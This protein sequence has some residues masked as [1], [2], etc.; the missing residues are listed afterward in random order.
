MSS[1]ENET[2]TAQ[3]SEITVTLCTF[4]TKSQQMHATIQFQLGSTRRHCVSC[5]APS[6][7]GS[8]S[9]HELRPAQIPEKKPRRHWNMMRCTQRRSTNPSGL[10]LQLGCLEWSPADPGGLC[11]HPVEQP[12]CGNA[13]THQ[14]GLSSTHD[15][16]QWLKK[17]ESYPEILF[18]RL[19]GSLQDAFS[20][21]SGT[22]AGLWGPTVGQSQL[23][24]AW[25]TEIWE[26][27]ETNSKKKQTKRHSRVNFMTSSCCFN[28]S[29][30]LTR[31]ENLREYA[32][33]S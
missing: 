18:I 12:L 21:L 27:E 33:E 22:L 23:I 17:I 14:P 20:S 10:L 7:D 25:Q 4:F 13:H 5:A 3:Q 11:L 29:L 24:Q 1:L 19:S 9:K 6:W 8:W 31:R 15:K 28:T 30:E 32:S 26:D 2:H 16:F